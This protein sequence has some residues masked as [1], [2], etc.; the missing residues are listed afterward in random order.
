MVH[1]STKLAENQLFSELSFA[2]G[3]PKQIMK[4]IIKRY[5]E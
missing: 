2:P 5:V 4:Q 3:A 1:R